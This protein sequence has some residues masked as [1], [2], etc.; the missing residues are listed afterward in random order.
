M[1]SVRE[2]LGQFLW[3]LKKGKEKAITENVVTTGAHIALILGT[4]LLIIQVLKYED[5][6][7]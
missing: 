7:K 4:L 1:P 6:T 3:D 2:I 5:Q